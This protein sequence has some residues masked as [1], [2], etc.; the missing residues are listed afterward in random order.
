MPQCSQVYITRTGLGS[1]G[2]ATIHHQHVVLKTNSRARP[3]LRRDR[4][5]G[6]LSMRIDHKVPSTSKKQKMNNKITAPPMSLFALLQATSAVWKVACIRT[7]HK[8]FTVKMVLTSKAL[9]NANW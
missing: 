5:T 3:S 4:A 6:K 2:I 8:K 1:R 9:I 7:G